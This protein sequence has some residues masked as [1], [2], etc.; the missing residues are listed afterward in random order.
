MIPNLVVFLPMMSPVEPGLPHACLSPQTQHATL[1]PMQL[2]TMSTCSVSAPPTSPFA[3]RIT[4]TESLNTHMCARTHTHKLHRRIC[5]TSNFS[6]STHFL[7]SDQNWQNQKLWLLTT[8][9]CNPGGQRENNKEIK[10]YC[11]DSTGEFQ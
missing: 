1:F 3:Q 10:I 2:S 5:N 4:L 11:T 9:V 7:C 8:G 6:K